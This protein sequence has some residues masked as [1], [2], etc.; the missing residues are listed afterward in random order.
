MMAARARRGRRPLTLLAAMCLLA[1]C[2]GSAL[3]IPRPTDQLLPPPP[4]SALE[5]S[6]LSFAV[7][8]PV[9]RLLEAAEAAFAPDVAQEQAWRAA[10]GGLGP[11]GLEVQY[12][13]WRESLYLEMVG[14]RLVSRVDLR[15]RVRARLAGGPVP[16][17]GQCGYD[18]EPPRRLRVTA[19]SALAWT[20]SWGIRST[21]SFGP[22]EFLDP[23][24]V[25]PGVADVTPVLGGLL[26]P[27]LGALARALDER[28]AQLGTRT[29]A[30]LVWQRL[31][32]PMEVAPRA[33]LVL[34]P[35]A[36][37]AG[38]ISGG[39]PGILR[40]VLEL[41]AEPDAR[42]GDAPDAEARP[43]P[44]LQLVKAPARRFHAV[45]PLQVPYAALNE[46][47]TSRVVG[48]TVDV[49][50]SRSLSVESVQA[51]GSGSQV[52]L[53]VQ[54]SGAA[55]GTVYLAGTPTVDADTRTL[56]V[57]DLQ[58]TLESDSALVRT[59]GRLLH[60]QLV[61]ALESRARLP[62]G[63]RLDA[64][65]TRLTAALN[66]ELAAGFHLSGAVDALE[67]RSVY[68]I[69]DGLEFRVLFGGTLGLVGR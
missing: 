29:E 67:V 6:L 66:R 20:E 5:P 23:C 9:A 63:D 58:F 28:V 2:G 33:W 19:S 53:A 8:V 36:A 59:T 69:Q 25:L 57:A 4:Q 46:W 43:L 37:H 51:Y 7:D 49:G 68:P 41:V 18:S 26:R 65:R 44:A 54:V 50:T 40:T 39:G 1:G 45:L 15:Y 17:A 16:L 3:S 47:L 60:R 21:T 30:A 52:I 56:R 14:D 61:S 22:P 42:I 32:A 48:T 64:L 27:G 12:R 10:P 13:L 34:R 24:G 38:P 55:S 31:S 11:A 35:R 62:L